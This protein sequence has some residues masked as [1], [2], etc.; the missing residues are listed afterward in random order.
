MSTPFAIRFI[1]EE[2]NP[3]V[4]IY[5]KWDGYI[6]TV[7]KFLAHRLQTM[8]IVN[9]VHMDLCRRQYAGDCITQLRYYSLGIENLASQ[10]V[11]DLNTGFRG[12]SLHPVSYGVEDHYSYIYEIKPSKVRGEYG[13]LPHVTCRCPGSIFGGIVYQ[14]TPDRYFDYI[15]TGED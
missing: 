8:E 11:A 3:I 1:D 6:G 12:I 10:I 14:G 9:S 5:C 15:I 13:V 7:G 4:E 2:N